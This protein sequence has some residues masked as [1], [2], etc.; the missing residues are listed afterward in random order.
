MSLLVSDKTRGLRDE[1]KSIVGRKLRA[2][3][4]WSPFAKRRVYEYRPNR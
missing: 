2:V 3:L 1:G 4:V